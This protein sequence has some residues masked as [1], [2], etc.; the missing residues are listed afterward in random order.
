[1][2]ASSYSMLWHAANII[3]SSLLQF[4]LLSIFSSFYFIR[5]DWKPTQTQ[6]CHFTTF[7]VLLCALLVFIFSLFR[8]LL[9]PFEQDE[10]PKKL[11]SQMRM[12]MWKWQ[13]R[14]VMSSVLWVLRNLQ[15]YAIFS[16]LIAVSAYH[17]HSS[18]F[19]EVATK[20]IS[21]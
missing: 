5:F 14:V 11:R 16:K 15:F 10:V 18:L 9:I 8:R 19:V 4:E 2:D 20:W 7:L 12:L 17:Y 13:S 21:K 6:C 3:F 1:M